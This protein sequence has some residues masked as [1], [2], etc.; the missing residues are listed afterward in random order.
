MR[1]LCLQLLTCLFP[2]NLIVLKMITLALSRTPDISFTYLLFYQSNPPRLYS[3]LK[4]VSNFLTTNDQ[5]FTNSHRIS[6]AVP[7]LFGTIIDCCFTNIQ[8]A[9]TTVKTM[10]PCEKTREIRYGEQKNPDYLES[11]VYLI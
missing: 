10:T 7:R 1:K 6:H 3:H 8:V 5:I 11:Q 2:H 9:V 4:F